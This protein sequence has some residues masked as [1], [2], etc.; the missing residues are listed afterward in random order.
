MCVGCRRSVGMKFM[1]V[2]PAKLLWIL[3]FERIEGAGKS[4]RTLQSRTRMIARRPRKPSGRLVLARPRRPL[5]LFDVPRRP[6]EGPCIKACRSAEGMQGYRRCCGAPP[7]MGHAQRS[8]SC[9][10]RA[11]DG[12]GL[13]ADVYA[14]GRAYSG[15]RD[16]R[17]HVALTSCR[18]CMVTWSYTVEAVVRLGGS[19]TRHGIRTP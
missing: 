13:I 9:V 2:A 11:V 3:P 16:S 12:H 7:A 4:K 1:K 8:R 14:S 5:R 19:W 18:S 17:G 6:P 15:H 10:H